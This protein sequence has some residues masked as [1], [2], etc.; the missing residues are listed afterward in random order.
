MEAIKEPIKISDSEWEV[1]RVIWTLGQS[2]AKEVTD[3]LSTN[4]NWKAATVKT[5]LGRLVKKGVLQPESQGKK[6]IYTPLVSEEA[7]VRSATENL[8]SH[9]CA[10][11]VG[12]T[13]TEMI[14]EAELT[15]ADMAMLR[16]ALDNKQPVAEIACNCI[17]GQC[18]CKVHTHDSFKVKENKR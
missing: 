14:T 16:D 10:Q 13:I 9:I 17:P 12:Q 18:Q 4:K 5:L 15:A 1:M 6:F 3:L 2:N 8:F 7:T 11:K